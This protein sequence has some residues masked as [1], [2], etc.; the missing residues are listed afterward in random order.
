M[1]KKISRTVI[2]CCIAILAT[3]KPALAQSTNDNFDTSLQSSYTVS[4]DE[5][6]FVEHIITIQNRTPEYYIKKYSLSVSSAAIANIQVSSNGNN[7]TPKTQAGK[8]STQIDI[9]FPDVLVGKDKTR[10]LIISY[11]NPDLARING[12]VLEVNIPHMANPEHYN[13]QKTI[14][15]TPLEFGLPNR[16]TPEDY[17]YE[18]DNKTWTLTFANTKGQGVS[19]I[20]GTEQIF[21]LTIRYH[22]NNPNNQPAITQVSL[23]PDTAWQKINYQQLEPQPRQL[24]QDLD[25]NWIAT[26]YLPANQTTEVNMQASVL[27]RTEPINPELQPEPK[28]EHTA[29]QKY[30][31]ATDSDILSLSQELTD[32]QAIY[33]YTIETLDYTEEEL[34]CEMERLGA[35][36]TLE[37]PHLATCQEF[38]DVFI[39]LAR[40]KQIPARRMVGYAH[41]ENPRLRPLSM[42]T[43]VLHT[44]PEYYNQEKKAWIPIDP[45]W[46][47][48][49]Q[50]VDYFNQFDLNHIV[51]AINGQSSQFPY[52]AGAYKLAKQETKDIKVQFA[53]EFIIDQANFSVKLEPEK[54]LQAIQMPGSYQLK[55]KNNTGAAWYN[56]QLQTQVPEQITAKLPKDSNQLNFLPYEE[57]TLDLGLYNKK[58][59]L[60]QTINWQLSLTTAANEN[61]NLTEINKNYEF[62]SQTSGPLDRYQ[63]PIERFQNQLKQLCQPPAVYYCLAGCVLTIALSTW[64]LLVLRRRREYRA[65]HRQSQK[66]EKKS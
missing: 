32:A 27:V 16:I 61:L 39:A 18:H 54:L 26:Y 55:I 63:K 51:F 50:G 23:P 52:A 30:W 37:T 43:D 45:T 2:L 66:P 64:G 12:K 56:V 4:N 9:E 47:D 21:D 31:P 28:S 49:T 15:H 6:T 38:T 24:E 46:G 3:T 22:L 42:V 58:Q 40:S 53:Q 17:S 5:K 29:A 11:Q 19:A 1:F 25:G 57:K 48:T 33:D 62:T 41:S 20:F 59:W 65:L 8:T 34:T 10:H 44:W 60:P 36:K 13:M 35:K 14:L 7:I